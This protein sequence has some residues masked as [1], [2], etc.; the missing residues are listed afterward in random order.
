MSGPEQVLF[1]IGRDGTSIDPNRRNLNSRE[2]LFTCAVVNSFV[3]DF[4]LRQSV[5]NHLSFFF[6]YGLP[7][8]RLSEGD[9]AF[10]P[11]AERTA[12]LVCT[13]EEFDDLAAEVG[14]GSQDGGRRNK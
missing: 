13:T 12:K 4:W 9:P 14:L 10:A 6:V 7:S 11:I 3:V 8:P 2:R 1:S 5:T